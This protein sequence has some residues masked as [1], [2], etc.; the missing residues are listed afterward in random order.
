MLYFRQQ[1][2][3]LLLQVVKLTIDQ[4]FETALR[5]IPLERVL[6]QQLPLL[7]VD[8]IHFT[9]KLRLQDM[10]LQKIVS[11]SASSRRDVVLGPLDPKLDLCDDVFRGSPSGRHFSDKV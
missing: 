8:Q 7:H 9:Q 10:R 2:L 6:R 1:K 11:H 4:V 5:V 3:E